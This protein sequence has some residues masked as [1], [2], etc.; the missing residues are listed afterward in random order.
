MATTEYFSKKDI[1]SELNCG[2]CHVRYDLP[3]CLP[4][5]NFI[6]S[7]CE[8]KYFNN[9]KDIKCPMCD[10]IHN[11]PPNGFP[12][13]NVLHKLLLKTP[14]SLYRGE[15]HKNASEQI[16]EIG[17][18]CKSFQDDFKNSTKII[19]SCCDEL[20]DRVRIK[21]ESLT[22]MINNFQNEIIEEIESYE[23]R[24]ICNTEKHKIFEN[25]I[26]NCEQKHKNWVAFLNDPNLK[27]SE[28]NSVLIEVEK[29]KKELT[30]SKEQFQAMIFDKKKLLFNENE[31]QIEPKIIGN[32]KIELLT[33]NFECIKQAKNLTNFY[34]NENNINVVI[35]C[36]FFAYIFFV[37]LLEL[38]LT[39]L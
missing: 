24:C 36:C 14:I 35:F 17:Y 16:D 26:I 34:F 21:A 5:A 18:L 38:S 25:L 15:I 12:M 20:K 27:D 28:I 37:Y 31:S 8:I 29:M 22:A 39:R 13:S 32:L 33:E 3:K 23:N 6:C 11:L 9:K 10:N 7:R 19:K 1:E 2:L 4:C 30:E